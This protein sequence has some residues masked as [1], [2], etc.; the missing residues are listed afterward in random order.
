MRLYS[1]RQSRKLR[2]N[3][4]RDIKLSKIW[5]GNE[6]FHEINLELSRDGLVALGLDHS[7]LDDARYACAANSFNR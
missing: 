2:G 6:S 7:H 1:G 4:K 3:G 5:E